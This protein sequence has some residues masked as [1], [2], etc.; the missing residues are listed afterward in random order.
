MIS[1]HTQIVA[2]TYLFEGARASGEQ[3]EL[4]LAGDVTAA[5]DAAWYLYASALHRS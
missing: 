2:L 1:L 4:S 3:A 5:E